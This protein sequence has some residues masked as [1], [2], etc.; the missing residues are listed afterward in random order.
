MTVE[1]FEALVLRTRC[2]LIEEFLSSVQGTRE[3]FLLFVEYL[4]DFNGLLRNLRK[5]WT[6]GDTGSQSMQPRRLSSEQG[7]PS[8]LQPRA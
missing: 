8:V 7:V 5:E 2:V 3:G 6:L 4:L 1:L